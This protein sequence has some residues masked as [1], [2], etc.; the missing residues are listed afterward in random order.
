MLTELGIDQA[1][2]TDGESTYGEEEDDSEWRSVTA[3]A[4]GMTPDSSETDPSNIWGSQDLADLNLL[5]EHATT[6]PETETD[7]DFFTQEL[8]KACDAVTEATTAK[9]EI[10]LQINA[11]ERKL[12]RA[13]ITIQE[14]SQELE[15]AVEK[16][17][18]ETQRLRIAVQTIRTGH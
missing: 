5:N 8:Q 12:I 16:V 4:A 15:E 3:T 13:Y 18:M 17:A 9:K 1:D 10:S 11:L 7:I 14:V 2:T 6:A